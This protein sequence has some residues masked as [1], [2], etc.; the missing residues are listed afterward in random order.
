MKQRCLNPENDSFWKYGAK[1]VTVC[2]RW[3]SFE[4]F[5]EDMGPRPDG[6][7]LDRID[8][9]KGYEPSNCRWADLTTQII[10]Q[11]LHGRNTTGIKGISWSTS[12]NKWK[13][14]IQRYGKKIYLARHT[15]FFEAC[16]I[17]KSFEA[18]EK[19]PN[20]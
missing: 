7:S 15:D 1:G 2:D 20:C 10:N 17:V 14:D 16:C 11:K 5:I 8:G 18:K 9:S 19:A 6:T 12:R 4:A 3:L 13:I